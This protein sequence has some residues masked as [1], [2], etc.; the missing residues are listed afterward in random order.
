MP[1]SS[2]ELP[3]SRSKTSTRID[4]IQATQDRAQVAAAGQLDAGDAAA[5]QRQHVALVDQVGGEED[6]QADLGELTGLD[7]E[8][9]HP[10]PDLGAVDLRQRRRQHAGSA[11]S[12]RPASASV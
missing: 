9:G 3:R 1:K 8:A 5:G 12:P 11:S 6:D 4:S 7:G 2:S 10:D